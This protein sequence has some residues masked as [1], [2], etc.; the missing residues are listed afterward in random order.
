[1]VFQRF[2]LF[3][4]MTVLENIQLAPL[5]VRKMPKAEAKAISLDL[6]G[7]GRLVG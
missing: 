5:K 2:N 7:E 3:P 6:P 4:H 1:M